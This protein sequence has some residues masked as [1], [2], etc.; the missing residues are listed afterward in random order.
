M[1]LKAGV[2]L[3]IFEIL[4]PLGAGG[5]GKVY[6]ARDTKLGR[7]V[8]MKTL[9][10][11]FAR[12]PERLARLRREARTLAS[13][14]HPNIA[15]IYGLEESGNSDWLALELVEGQNLRGPLPTPE[16]LRVA[17]QIAEAL[18]AAHEKGIVHRDLKPANVRVTQQGRVKV[19]DF[20][21]AK[22]IWA[23]D[24]RQPSQN[25]DVSQLPTETRLET[26]AG[27]IMGTPGYMSPEQALGRDVDH[28]TD[29]WAFGCVLYELLTGERT[30]R[31]GAQAETL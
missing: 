29:I 10:S 6:R 2:H 28:R 24:Q 15:A 23:E 4:S 26:L 5:M 9:P 12:N 22:A 8:A 17:K 16:A 20:G 25:Q 21:L 3:G 18:E 13:L 19:L 7:D 30:F 31:G 11:E 27:R 1:G 14:N